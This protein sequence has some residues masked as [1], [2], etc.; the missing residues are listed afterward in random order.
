[1]SFY[2]RVMKKANHTLLLQPFFIVC[3]LALLLNDFVLKYAY[4]NWLTGKLS[5]FAG[6]AAFVIFFTSL[7]PQKKKWVYGL[8]I[9]AFAWWK[10]PLSQPAI[11]F[12]NT[13]LHIPVSRVVDY[14]DYV[15]FVILF[16]TWPLQPVTVST[17]YKKTATYVLGGFSVFAFCATEAPRYMQAPDNRLYFGNEYKTTLSEKEILY[18]LDSMHISYLK[19]SFELS[20]MYNRGQFLYTQKDTTADTLKYIYIPN[21]EFTRV[22]NRYPTQAYIRITNFVIDGDTLPRIKLRVRESYNK[23]NFIEF[24]D[25]QLSAKTFETYISKPGNIRNEYRKRIYTDIIAKLR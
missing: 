9:I 24:D 6:L 21:D 17:V 2:I 22:Y 19:D 5:D 23:R 3:L 8:T 12:C 7:L 1:M 4:H 16:F 25:M 10:S 20:R 14:T 18:R 13:V 15:A 11:D